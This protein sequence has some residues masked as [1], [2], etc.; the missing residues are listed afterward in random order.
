MANVTLLTFHRVMSE[1][2]IIKPPFEKQTSFLGFERSG[3]KEFLTMTSPYF[4]GWAPEN[5][6]F[7][8]PWL[9]CSKLI[10]QPLCQTPLK[11]KYF[12]SRS[13]ILLHD[14]RLGQRFHRG[15]FLQWG[16]VSPYKNSCE[17]RKKKPNPHP[18]LSENIHCLSVFFPGSSPCIVS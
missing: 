12:K 14:C 6:L 8:K 15:R 7:W 18:Q 11:G 5:I 3:I 10:R 16:E 13:N 2:M 4:S 17:L 9:T 1:R